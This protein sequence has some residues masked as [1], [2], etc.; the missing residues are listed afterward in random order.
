MNGSVPEEYLF[1]PNYDWD[2]LLGVGHNLYNSCNFNGS[3]NSTLPTNF[4][5]LHDQ[6][7][8]PQF[9]SAFSPIYEPDLQTS[10][11]A[12][13]PIS[14][15]NRRLAS[16]AADDPEWDALFAEAITGLMPEPLLP[17]SIVAEGFDQ[18]GVHPANVE[19]RTRAEPETPAVS[20]TLCTS[21]ASTAGVSLGQDLRR[22]LGGCPGA[23]M[24]AFLVYGGDFTSL[25]IL[26]ATASPPSIVSASDRAYL[27]HAVCIQY[28]SRTN[29]S[30]IV[31]NRLSRCSQ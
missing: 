21:A 8:L 4:D 2:S 14:Q 28:G 11:T 17:D 9:P 6:G 18:M 31:F 3:D 30:N 24:N 15:N 29:K 22:S 10:S 5:F 12:D 16:A 1:G 19:L 26:I 13:N 23:G 25:R 27:F 20:S 7:E